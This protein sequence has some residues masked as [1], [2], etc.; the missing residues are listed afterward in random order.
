MSDSVQIVCPCCGAV[1][2]LKCIPSSVTNEQ[3]KHEAETT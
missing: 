1:V 3:D 2:L